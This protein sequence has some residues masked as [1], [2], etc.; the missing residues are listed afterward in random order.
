MKIVRAKDVNRIAVYASNSPTVCEAWPVTRVMLTDF[1]V[2]E[3]DA[4]VDMRELFSRGNI[5]TELRHEINRFVNPVTLNVNLS[6][7]ALNYGRR[8]AGLPELKQG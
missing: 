3:I 5:P 1:E 6:Q 4:S 8:L 7:A 2:S